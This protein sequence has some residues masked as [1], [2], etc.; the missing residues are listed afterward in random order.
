MD[1]SL[2]LAAKIDRSGPK[3]DAPIIAPEFR[4]AAF[5]KKQN[6][7]AKKGISVEL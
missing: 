6:R 1:Q 3:P 5:N 4:P 7:E 2:G